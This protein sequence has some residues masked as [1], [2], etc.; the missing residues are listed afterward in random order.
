MTDDS[1]TDGAGIAGFF[2]SVLV[3]QRLQHLRSQAQ[4][5]RHRDQEEAEPV[6]GHDR[7]RDPDYGAGDGSEDEALLGPW[8]HRSTFLPRALSASATMLSTISLAPPT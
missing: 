1:R 7:E 2:G 3:F 4:D 5:G 6:V 8:L